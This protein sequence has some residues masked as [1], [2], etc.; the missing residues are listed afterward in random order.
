MTM[1]E[2]AAKCF[3]LV[4]VWAQERRPIGITG[5]DDPGVAPVVVCSDGTV[6]EARFGPV[7][8]SQYMEDDEGQSFSCFEG[9]AGWIPQV[10]I[11]GTRA[12]LAETCLV[13]EMVRDGGSGRGEVG[14]DGF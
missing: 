10:P 1:E 7:Q 9:I 14:E 12:A 4:Q 6:W 13:W 2:M 8:T 3:A 5:S 11:P